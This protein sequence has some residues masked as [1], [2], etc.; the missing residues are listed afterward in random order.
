MKDDSLEELL[1]WDITE[2]KTVTAWSSQVS[3]KNRGRKTYSRRRGGSFASR[4][5]SLTSSRAFSESSDPLSS[6]DEETAAELELGIPPP[7]RPS[8]LARANSVTMHDRQQAP[9]MRRANSI[10]HS[11]TSSFQGS[12]TMLVR[13]SSM[14]RQTFSSLS[15][16][17]ENLDPNLTALEE[18]VSPKRSKPAVDVRGRKK[19]RAENS[20]PKI[21]VSNCFSNLAKFGED[22]LS[23]AKPNASFSNNRIATETISLTLS[24]KKSISSDF[25]YSEFTESSPAGAS[26]GS[27][28]KRGICGSPLDDFDDCSFSAAPSIRRSYFFSPASMSSS[29][30]VS[31]NEREGNRDLLRSGSSG[32]NKLKRGSSRN[33]FESDDALSD[34]EDSGDDASAESMGHATTPMDRFTYFGN[35][36]R[37]QSPLGYSPE[38]LLEPGKAEANDVIKS[39]SSHLDL[40]FLVKSLR[41]EKSGSRASWHVAPPVAWDSNRRSAFFQWTTRSLGF[42][43]RAGGMAVAYLQISKSKGAR[44]LELLESAVASYKQH[45]LGLET[46]VDT[47]EKPRFPFSIPMSRALSLTP[48][49]CVCVFL[50]V[51]VEYVG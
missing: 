7:P 39:M 4:R 17:S 41:K 10:S 46:P 1:E 6:Q 45:G 25:D 27:N 31:L 11:S 47:T 30:C 26:S 28:R 16:L 19:V 18:L 13:Q 35:N 29:P 34:A 43:F 42:S 9:R 38:H 32:S 23:W 51:I 3:A 44:M 12:G 22:G 2:N 36:Q 50:N 21:P 49:E 15:D 20:I 37:R 48:K 5:G 14:P 24:H 33:E 8:K 40:R